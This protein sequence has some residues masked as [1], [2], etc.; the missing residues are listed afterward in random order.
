MWRQQLT[1]KLE[2]VA[3]LANRQPVQCGAA[4][5][6]TGLVADHQMLLLQIQR[7]MPCKLA[8]RSI[9]A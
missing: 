3:T 5:Q 4:T 6:L 8:R 2:P 7:Q 1:D 9:W